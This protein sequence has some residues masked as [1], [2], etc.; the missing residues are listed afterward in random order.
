MINDRALKDADTMNLNESSD[1]RICENFNSEFCFDGCVFKV[2]PALVYQL[3]H[4]R[5]NRLLF[6][7]TRLASRS[8]GG[9]GR[10]I[11]RAWLCFLVSPS[12]AGCFHGGH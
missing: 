12:S 9:T 6:L 10:S 8:S 3:P 7:R 4:R 1:Y 5:T 11:L 2:F